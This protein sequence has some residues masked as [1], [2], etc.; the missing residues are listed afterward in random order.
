M[1]NSLQSNIANTINENT[2]SIVDETEEGDIFNNH[3]NMVNEEH[4]HS[5]G[6]A[7][8]DITEEQSKMNKRFSEMTFTHT[9]E[10][11]H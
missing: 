4:T 6:A 9:E 2:E 8:L 7:I 11:Q 5:I 10:G 3:D 1:D